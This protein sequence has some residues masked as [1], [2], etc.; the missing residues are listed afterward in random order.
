MQNLTD[1]QLRSKIAE[2]HNKYQAARNEPASRTSDYNGAPLQ[3]VDCIRRQESL[4]EEIDLLKAELQSRTAPDGEQLYFILYDRKFYHV[5]PTIIE[6]GRLKKGGM[7]DNYFL[8]KGEA[9]HKSYVQGRHGKNLTRVIYD[10]V[11]ITTGTGE[12]GKISIDLSL[13]GKK[14]TINADFRLSGNYKDYFY[15][16][17]SNKEIKTDTDRGASSAERCLC[18]YA[19][20]YMYR[21]MFAPGKN[22]NIR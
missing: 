18:T 12:F 20:A 14:F 8:G 22:I 21:E 9:E 6:K 17:L 11:A 19:A 2:L 1:D 5:I 4:Y 15:I 3:S 10:R 16:E 13:D 7:L